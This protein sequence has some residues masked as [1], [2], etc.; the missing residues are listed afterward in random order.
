M[1]LS[2]HE[3]LQIVRI[4]HRSRLLRYPIDPYNHR[5]LPGERRE[6]IR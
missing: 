3:A 4:D 5:P 6:R 2:S 1:L